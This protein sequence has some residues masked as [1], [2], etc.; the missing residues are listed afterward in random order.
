MLYQN[1]SGP[2]AAHT[3]NSTEGRSPTAKPPAPAT[4][5][6]RAARHDV[7][8][9]NTQ[10]AT[11]AHPSAPLGLSQN[12]SAQRSPAGNHFCFHVSH[13]VATSGASVKISAFA[14]KPSTRGLVLKTA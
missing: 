3:P 7:Q 1:R 2:P 12:A 5:P 10:I 6:A 13:A 14:V 8:V 11:S 4:A 9:A